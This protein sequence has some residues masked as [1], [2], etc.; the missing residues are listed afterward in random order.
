MHNMDHNKIEDNVGSFRASLKNTL[1]LLLQSGLPGTMTGWRVGWLRC[2]VIAK[3]VITS[4]SY[5]TQHTLSTPL[6]LILPP[7]SLSLPPHPL[8]SPPFTLR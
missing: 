3:R 2:R 7:L 4:Q 5:Q 1:S 8:P 6:V